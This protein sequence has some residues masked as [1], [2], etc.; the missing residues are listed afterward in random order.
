MS[1]T[2]WNIQTYCCGDKL[3]LGVSPAQETT[4]GGSG[5]RCLAG[6]RKR[7]D[8]DEHPADCGF[9]LMGVVCLVWGGSTCGEHIELRQ[10]ILP[11]RGSAASREVF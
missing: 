10:K 3:P 6:V 11:D 7:V 2:H 5:W 8:G 4:H 1:W 9:L